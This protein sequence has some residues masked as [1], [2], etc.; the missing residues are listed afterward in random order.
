M[1]NIQQQIQTLFQQKQENGLVGKELV[2]EVIKETAKSYKQSYPNG[3]NPLSAMTFVR[4]VSCICQEAQR[5]DIYISD[6]EV[7]TEIIKGIHHT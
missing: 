6:R 3:D 5:I 7:L 1:K 4:V 2:K